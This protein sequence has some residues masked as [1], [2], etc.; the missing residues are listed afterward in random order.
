MRPLTVITGI[1]LGSCLSITVSLGAVLLMFLLLGNEYPRLSAEFGGLLASM[2][3]FLS[4][5]GVSA[6][7]F[8]V[9]LKEHPQWQWAQAFMWTGLLATGYYYWP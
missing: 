3:I 4:M 1:V 7:S 2:L 6:L 8:Y 9:L 5:T